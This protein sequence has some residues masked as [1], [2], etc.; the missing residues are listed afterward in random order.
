MEIVERVTLWDVMMSGQPL[1]YYS[2]G[3][4]WW[5]HNPN[6]LHTTP[7]PTEENIRLYAET[8]MESSSK[9]DV[10]L[11]EFIELANKALSHR[12]PCDPRG[13]ILM[14]SDLQGFLGGARK[15]VEQY[16]KHGLRAFMAAHHSNSQFSLTDPRPWAESSWDAYNEALDRLDERK[17]AGTEEAAEH[18]PSAEEAAAGTFMGEMMRCV[19]CGKE[20]MS[21]PTRESNWRCMV[22]GKQRYYA[23]TD[24]FPADGSKVDEF[25]KAYTKV[26]TKV[27]K[28]KGMKPAKLARR[29]QID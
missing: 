23:C 2:V 6:H 17:R 9:P 25:Q 16:G 4:C 11:E 22:V 26:I 10:P 12:L 13:A 28:L 14:Q 29:I 18:E 1:I 5:T 7:P 3:T 8:L 21:T 27:A 20:E 24:E 19:M 15:S